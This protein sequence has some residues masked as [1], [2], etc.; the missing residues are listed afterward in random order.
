MASERE[1]GLS[2]MGKDGWGGERSYNPCFSAEGKTVFGV[3]K[4][5]V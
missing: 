2:G 5:W 1:E 3:Q 4:T